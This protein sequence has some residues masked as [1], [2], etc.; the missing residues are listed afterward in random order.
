ML[1]GELKNCRKCGTMFNFVGGYPLCG[2]CRA[3]EEED[4]QKV[5]N[6]LYDNPGSSPPEIAKAI[7]V[8][9]DKIRRFLKEGRLEIVGDVSN[10]ILACEKCGKSIRS[11]RF[12]DECERDMKKELM[13]EANRMSSSLSA[14]SEKKKKGDSL[15]Y[16]HKE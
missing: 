7:D 13:M 14:D 10:M 16:L 5:K 8:S 1:M 11:G 6:Y 4:F 2:R 15:R 9:V 12:C 3:A